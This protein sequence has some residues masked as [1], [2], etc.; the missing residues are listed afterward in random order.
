MDVCVSDEGV[1]VC[2]VHARTCIVRRAWFV[3]CSLA[4][5]EHRSVC[6]R[7]CVSLSVSVLYCMYDVCGR[8]AGLVVCV[9]SVCVFFI[10]TIIFTID[11]PTFASFSC[12]TVR[13]ARASNWRPSRS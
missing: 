6:V 1:S 7:V 3:S 13:A 10:I 12:E 2:G 8:F 11:Q 5:R 9:L 4:G